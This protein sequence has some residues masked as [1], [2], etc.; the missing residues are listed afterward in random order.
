MVGGRGA[1]VRLEEVVVD[2]V[3]G[4]GA[5]RKPCHTDVAVQPRDDS[6]C[7]AG[8][9]MWGGGFHGILQK[10]VGGAACRDELSAG[11]APLG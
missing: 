8:V 11:G 9:E 6:S 7:E 5:D 2:D 4:D 3:Q 10:S 1:G